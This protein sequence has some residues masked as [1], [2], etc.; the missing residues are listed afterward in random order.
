[1]DKV[2]EA[3]GS[4]SFLRDKGKPF[5]RV[6]RKATGLNPSIIVEA[7][8][9]GCRAD[10]HLQFAGS[11]TVKISR[12]GYEVLIWLTKQHRICYSPSQGSKFLFCHLSLAFFSL[13]YA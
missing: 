13:T 6:G 11:S 5:E 10:Q 1:M 4:L 9:R 3:N 12:P 2:R 8:Q 7:W